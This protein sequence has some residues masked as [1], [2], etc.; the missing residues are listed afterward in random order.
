MGSSSGT[1][2]TFTSEG[3]THSVTV[4]SL[5]S[6]TYPSSGT[7]YSEP[8]LIFKNSSRYWYFKV[9]ITNGGFFRVNSERNNVYGKAIIDKIIRSSYKT[10]TMV[11]GAGLQVMSGPNQYVRFG[12]N[13]NLIFGDLAVKGGTDGGGTGYFQKNLTV[14]DT[15]ANTSYPMYVVGDLAATGNIIAYVSSDIRLKE[16]ITPLENS[17]EKLKKLNAVDFL[18]KDKT[19]GWATKTPQD[20]GLIAQEVEKVFPSL[21]G[22]MSDGY[23]GIRYD[24][25]V[26]VLVDSIKTQDKKIDDLQA[27][28]ETLVK[29]MQE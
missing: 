21:V 3:T 4:A 29:K 26:P 20:I 14:G 7:G 2:G 24:R 15:E 25:L 27:L 17:L 16:H 19:K 10:K 13:Q 9:K 8:T 11:H 23:K 5:D 6:S 12:K 28:V 22:E 1:A 18:W